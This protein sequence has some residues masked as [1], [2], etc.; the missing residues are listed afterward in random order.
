MIHPGVLWPRTLYKK[1]LLF[2]LLFLWFSLFSGWL[3]FSSLTTSASPLSSSPLPELSNNTVFPAIILRAVFCLNASYETKKKKTEKRKENGRRW[4]KNVRGVHRK[5]VPSRVFSL[6][7]FDLT[8][9]FVV[10]FF[11]FFFFELLIDKEYS[12][13]RLRDITISL[14]IKIKQSAK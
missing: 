7:S 11:F 2:L 14:W 12:V 10:F 4:N 9:L 13:Q 1:A 5:D 6:W 3:I 8:F